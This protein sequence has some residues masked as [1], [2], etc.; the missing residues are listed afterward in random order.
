MCITEGL[1]RAFAL[2]F[3]FVYKSQ[4]RFVAVLHA[5]QQPDGPEY[6]QA[7]AAALAPPGGAAAVQQPAPAAI[8]AQDH[9]QEA[10]GPGLGRPAEDAPQQAA[11]PVQSMYAKA[12][13]LATAY[14][15]VFCES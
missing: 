1:H 3:C 7:M 10:H 11:V 9:A 12:K 15:V 13:A 4:D 8:A 2:R 14:R 6:A 5:Q